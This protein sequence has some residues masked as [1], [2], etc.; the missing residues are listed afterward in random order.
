MKKI[1]AFLLCVMMLASFATCF[2]EE[3]TQFARAHVIGAGNRFSVGIR[4]DGKIIVKGGMNE[5]V[6]EQEKVREW[7]D[8]VS[9]DVGTNHIVGLKSNGRVVAA[10]QHNSSTLCAVNHWAD[11]VSVIAGHDFTLGLKNDGTIISTK[12]GYLVQNCRYRRRPLA[13]R[14]SSLR[15]QGRCRRPQPVR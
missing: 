13:D 7:S 12:E 6:Y 5:A 14:R 4:C 2:A 1:I 15:R 11:I 10:S 8:I 3:S 9:I